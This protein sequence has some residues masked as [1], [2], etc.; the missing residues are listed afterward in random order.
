MIRMLWLGLSLQWSLAGYGLGQV[1]SGRA[2][3]AASTVASFAT[4]QMVCGFKRFSTS[5]A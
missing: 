1:R 4:V 5:V 2:E 3:E